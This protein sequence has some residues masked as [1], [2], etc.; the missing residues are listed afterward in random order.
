MGRENYSCQRS[1]WLSCLILGDLRSWGKQ[2]ITNIISWELW[3]LCFCSYGRF[4]LHILSPS[5]SH[6]CISLLCHTLRKVSGTLQQSSSQRHRLLL[7]L[8]S[9]VIVIASL[10][11]C[12]SFLLS[13]LLILY[14]QISDWI[15]QLNSVCFGNSPVKAHVFFFSSAVTFCLCEPYVPN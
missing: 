8:F 7:R 2:M 11:K 13:S 6:N 3:K 1:G 15:K 14:W 5:V 9:S 12:P 10:T 4:K